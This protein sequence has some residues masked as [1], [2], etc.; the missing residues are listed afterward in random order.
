[1]LRAIRTSRSAKDTHHMRCLRGLFETRARTAARFDCLALDICAGIG[2]TVLG[3][4]C[5]VDWLMES[6][7]TLIGKGCICRNSLV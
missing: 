3:R 4:E 5:I 2:Y 7:L 6:N 1:M